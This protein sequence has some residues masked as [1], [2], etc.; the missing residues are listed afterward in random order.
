MHSR[1]PRVLLAFTAV[2]ILVGCTSNNSAQLPDADFFVS[3]GAPFLIRF[4]ESAGVQTPSTFVIVQM[5]DVLN[6]SRCP[7]TV[8]CVDAGFVTVRLAVQTALTVQDVDIEVPPDGTVDVQVEEITIQILQVRPA[9]QEGVTINLIDYEVAMRLAQTG[10][11][12]V[13]QQ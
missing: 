9:A 2:A 10:D 6:D 3:Q 1:S 11:L 7:A 12:G 5:S 8:Q 4:G 13:P